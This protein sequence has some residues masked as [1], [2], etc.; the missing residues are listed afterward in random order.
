MTCSCLY[1]YIYIYLE[2]IVKYINIYSVLYIF[3]FIYTYI[4][5]ILYIYHIC[6]ICIMLYPIVSPLQL[7][8]YRTIPAESAGGVSAVYCG[9]RQAHQTGGPWWGPVM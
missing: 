8:V 2:T 6:I 9:S 5:Y 4:V 3:F 7:F 1:V